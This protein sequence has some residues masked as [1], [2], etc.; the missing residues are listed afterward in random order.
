M[1]FDSTFHI[2]N[3]TTNDDV[4]VYTVHVFTLS[5]RTREHRH[6]FVW[7]QTKKMTVSSSL[8]THHHC[9]V[10]GRLKISSTTELLNGSLE[11]NCNELGLPISLKRTVS[12]GAI[13]RI[14]DPTKFFRLS[15]K[16]NNSLDT[17]DWYACT[18]SLKYK[19][20]NSYIQRCILESGGLFEHLFWKLYQCSIFFIFYF[21]YAYR[22]NFK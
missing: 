20:P 18:S 1:T 9:N 19:S 15:E 11:E 4:L 14:V 7:R 21:K 12:S 2:I 17:R 22:N 8:N 16:R 10:R 5:V 3:Q 6:A 13:W